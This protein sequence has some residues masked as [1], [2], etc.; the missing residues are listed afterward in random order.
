MSAFTGKWNSDGTLID[1]TE[2]N[3][4]VTVKYNSVR[5]PFTGFEI[6]LNSPV[7]SVDF[8]DAQVAV[9]GVLVNGDTIAWSN[10]TSWTKA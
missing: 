8:K 4:I 9:T 10:G 3:N 1:I 5:G 2:A 7:I 6:A